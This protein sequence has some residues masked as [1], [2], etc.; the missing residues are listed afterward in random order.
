MERGSHLD[1]ISLAHE[2]HMSPRTLSRKLAKD[3][4]SFKDLL[5]DVRITAAKDLLRQ[6]DLPIKCVAFKVGYQ[7]SDSFSRVFKTQTGQSPARW[8]Q[9]SCM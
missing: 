1:L 4:A 5:N 2:F 6:T 3:N 8:K 7:N 9:T